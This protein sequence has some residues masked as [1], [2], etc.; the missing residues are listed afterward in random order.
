MRL[1]S[2][3]DMMM[4]A[5]MMFI[6]MVLGMSMQMLEPFSEVTGY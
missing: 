2:M 6:P 4:S 3:R 1:K 5:A